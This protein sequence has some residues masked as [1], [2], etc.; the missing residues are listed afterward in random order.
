[1]AISL[2][3]HK[4]NRIWKVFFLILVSMV[5]TKTAN[6]YTLLFYLHTR[7]VTGSES[8]YPFSTLYLKIR[9][10]LSAENDIE[11]RCDLCSTKCQEP[12]ERAD[13]GKIKLSKS[14]LLI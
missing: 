3:H 6:R 13:T 10:G 7:D 12:K 14:K 1:M 5:F 4:R 8:I 11:F 2:V 9:G